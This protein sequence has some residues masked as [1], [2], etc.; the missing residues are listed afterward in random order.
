M[1]PLAA[2]EQQQQPT[3]IDRQVAFAEVI[4]SEEHHLAS[5]LSSRWESASAARNA[6]VANVT[7]VDALPDGEEWIDASAPGAIVMRTVDGVDVANDEEWE[8]VLTDFDWEL[9]FRW[10]RT[11]FISGSML[12][13]PSEATIEWEV[14]RDAQPGKYRFVYNGDAKDATG[15]IASFRGIT[16]PF[17]VV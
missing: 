6:L 15:K 16:G 14:G 3:G 17:E 4:D 8:T 9:V 12:G 7:Q 11:S 10:K 13:G 1:R 5:I 2:A